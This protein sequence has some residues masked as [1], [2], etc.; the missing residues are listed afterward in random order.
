MHLWL[1]GRQKHTL[2]GL[3][4]S[5]EF[6]QRLARHR[7]RLSHGVP[8]HAATDGGKR[9]GL[10]VVLAREL[11]A[12]QVTT[13]EQFGL[14]CSSP[15]PHRAN[16]VN[17]VTRGEPEG[18]SDPGLASGTSHPGPNLGHTSARI[19]ELSA[20]CAMDGTVHTAPA[21]HRLVGGIDDGVNVKL[22]NVGL[23]DTN[24]MHVLKHPLGRSADGGPLLPRPRRL[25]PARSLTYQLRASPNQPIP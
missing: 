18:R 5:K 1:I 2:Q 25:S 12:A 7:G 15:A 13:R 23:D 24:T 22:R 9:D 10:E 20:R 3:I 8:V 6:R 4:A 11:Q 17:D 21:K 16:C 19:E 14:A